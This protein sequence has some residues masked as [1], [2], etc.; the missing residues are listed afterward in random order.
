MSMQ[1]RYLTVGAAARHYG[2]TPV[3]IRRWMDAGRLVGLRTL[4]GHRR[5]LVPASA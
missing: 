1:P 2:V 3:T 5:V 4:G